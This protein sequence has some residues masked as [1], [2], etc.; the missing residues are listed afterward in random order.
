LEAAEDPSLVAS[1]LAVLAISK[2]QP[3]LG[4]LAAEFTEDER[5]EMIKFWEHR[6]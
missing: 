4:S 1:I 2:G 3:T 5:R 6:G